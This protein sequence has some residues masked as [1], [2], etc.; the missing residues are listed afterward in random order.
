M[1]LNPADFSA[2]VAA[3]LS[4]LAEAQL[5]RARRMVT[6]VS[7]TR[8]RIGDREYVNFA[9]NDYLGLTHHPRLIATAAASVRRDGVGSG[10]AALITGYSD[11]HARAEATIARW[12]GTQDAVLLPSGYQANQ[13][14]IQTL[15][16]IGQRA[17]G[18]V[19]FLID[20][21]AHASLL[22]AV[23]GG[24]A[25]FRVFPH[26]RLAK[27]ERLLA[28]APTGQLQVVVTESIFSMDGDAGD[29]MGFV[30]LKRNHPFFLVVD[31]AHGSGVYG[32]AGSGYASEIGVQSNVDASVV[33]LSK[34]IGCVGGV[35]C[36]SKDFCGAVVN[37]G[38]AYVFTTAVPPWAAVTASEAIAVM[39]DEPWRQERVRALAGRVRAAARSMGFELPPGDSPIVPIILGESASAL[40]AAESLARAGLLVVAVRP[41]T[42]AKGTSR[43][44]V[45]L[46]AAHTDGEIDQLL[47]ELGALKRNVK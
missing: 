28:D 20:K 25:A 39:R 31:E 18:G 23:R 43:L 8:V 1:S 46:S 4:S 37:H 38:R 12:K 47:S 35:I 3:D 30:E 32:P 33:T 34:A 11:A 36:G 40:S 44:R 16:A 15:V 19:R 42:V 29:L 45:T 17:E 27:V 6:P 9:S 24:S 14:L 21:L 5:L 41:P 26:N 22:D 2:L 7:A 10:A 13:A